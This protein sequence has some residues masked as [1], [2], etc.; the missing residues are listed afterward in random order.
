MM[1]EMSRENS[2][3]LIFNYY[4]WLYLLTDIQVKKIAGFRSDLSDLFDLLKDWFFDIFLL[5]F[6]FLL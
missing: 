2:I 6:I 5:L 1:K 4:D 3:R